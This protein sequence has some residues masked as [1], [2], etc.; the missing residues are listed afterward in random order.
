M[1]L[2]KLG[3]S[4]I[5]YMLVSSPNVVFADVKADAYYWSGSLAAVCNLY[6]DGEISVTDA[7]SYVSKILPIVDELPKKYKDL[8]YNFFYEINDGSCR[9]LVP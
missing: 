7:K 2:N 9:N 4:L 1:K 5:T 8:A 3:L 6:R